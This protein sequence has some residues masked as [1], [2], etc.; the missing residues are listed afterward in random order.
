MTIRNKGT[1]DISAGGFI[2]NP[3][4]SKKLLDLPYCIVTIYSDFGSCRIIEEFKER[5]ILVSGRIKVIE[6]EKKEIIVSDFVPAQPKERE[7]C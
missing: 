1:S 3:N 2:I 6:N 4:E 7:I 5:T